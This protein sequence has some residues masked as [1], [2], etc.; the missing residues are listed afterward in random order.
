MDRRT[1]DLRNLHA[2]QQH[3]P[4]PA[5][6][7]R[8]RPGLLAAPCDANGGRV[9][10]WTTLRYCPGGCHLVAS[11]PPD[12]LYHSP[13]DGVVLWDGGHRWCSMPMGAPLHHDGGGVTVPFGA[14]STTPPDEE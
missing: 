1:I 6:L 9:G 4:R 10:A 12:Q 8:M 7:P 14:V 2:F 13:I 3:E 5:P 11:W